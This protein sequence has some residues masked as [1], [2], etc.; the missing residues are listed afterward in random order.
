MS[1]DTNP[2]M[3]IWDSVK[4]TS[5]SHTKTVKLGGRDVTSI[6]GMYMAQRATETFGP[7]G[8]GWGWTV[9]EERFDQGSPIFNDKERKQQLGNEVVNTIH[10]ELWYMQGGQRRTISQYGHTP[11]IMATQ[12][13]P[14]TDM[15]ASK[16]SMTDA[17]KKCLSMLGFS[18][19]I[20]L[21]MFEDQEYVASARVSDE[22]AQADN[23][24]DELIKQR[25]AFYAEINAAIEGFKLIPN[26]AALNSVVTLALRKA[27]RRCAVLKIDYKEIEGHLLKARNERL[28]ELN[29]PAKPELVCTECGVATSGDAGSECLECGAS[30]E[31]LDNNQPTE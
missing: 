15:D 19:D 5:P 29:P 26:S 10:L 8:T 25:T 6:N 28:Q 27:N 18:A 2:N 23:A 12:Y 24:D 14:K 31:E 21:G 13:G 9:L 17:M 4:A 22:I 11:F 30:C 20:F 7:A 16:K 3:L 1:K